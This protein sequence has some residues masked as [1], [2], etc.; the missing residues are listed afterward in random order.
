VIGTKWDPAQGEVPRPDTINEAM[1]H[2]QKVTCP[3]CSPKDP[4]SSWKDQ[5]QIFAPNQWTEAAYPCC[6]IR[7]CWKTLRRK[8]IL[9][10]DQQSQLIWSPEISQTLAHQPDNIHQL[11]W[12]PQ[13]IYS[14]RLPGLCLFRDDALN[15]Q[16]TGGPREFKGQVGWGVG[17]SMWRQVGG[18]E[19][20]DVEESEGRWG[21][22]IK[23]G[24]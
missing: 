16:E 1:E 11:I 22:G 15:S 7:E 18:E 8:A 9:L 5:I 2:S 20:W 6:W 12:G 23:Y 13:H 4:T 24:V 19:V 10:E 21:V 14:R 3:D 17:I